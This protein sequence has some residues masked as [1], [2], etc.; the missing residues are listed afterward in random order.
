[1]TSS[2]RHRAWSLLVTLVA[3][4]AC[5][6][7][8]TERLKIGLVRVPA[9]GLVAI[10]HEEGFFAAEGLDVSVVDIASGRESL[11][12]ALEGRVDLATAVGMSV[13]REVEEGRAPRILA[14]I[15]HASRTTGLV[16]RADRGIRSAADLRGKLVGYS[17]ASTGEAF[18]RTLLTAEGMR[19]DDVRAEEVRIEEVVE[20]LISGRLDAA[21][22]WNPHLQR[23]VGALGPSRAIRLHTDMFVERSMLLAREEVVATRRPVLLRALRALARAERLAREDPERAFAAFRRS[24]P[25]EDGASL[26][27]QWQDVV[28]QLEI[29]NALLQSLNSQ[30]SLLHGA[31]GR[32]SLPDFRRLLVPELLAA[33][34]PDAVTLER[35]P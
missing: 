9:T 18:L 16:A 34:E 13:L 11:A 17:R 3:A 25:Q 21:A 19:W 22:L 29:S 1:M 35:L 14:G 6:A 27:D 33:V 20:A 30:A 15:H 10:A 26:R 12:A 2:L 4:L 8:P 23:A 5:T 7:R 32:A 28:P 24:L 31:A